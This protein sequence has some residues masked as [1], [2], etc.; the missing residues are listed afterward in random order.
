MHVAQIKFVAFLASQLFFVHAFHAGTSAII[1]GHIIGIVFQ[2]FTVHFAHISQSMRRHLTGIGAQRASLQR[3]TRI[4]EEL[5]LQR[6]T[7]FHTQLR[8]KKLGRIGRISRIQTTVAQSLH[9][10]VEILSRDVQLSAERQSI[11]T[12]HFAGRHHQ[13][14]VDAVVG[15]HL[16]MTVVDKSAF[17]INRFFV[18]GIAVGRTFVFVRKQLQMR[19]TANIHQSHYHDHRDNDH[20]TTGII[21]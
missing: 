8:E 20:R 13:V 4:I 12:F 9:A 1:A 18:L 5:F 21:F 17:G 2:V 3:K 19:Q 16:A 14:V 7:L 15:Q 11:E 10:L 6:G